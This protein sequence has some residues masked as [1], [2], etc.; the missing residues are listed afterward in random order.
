MGNP[1]KVKNRV[2][3]IYREDTVVSLPE[4]TV[5]HHHTRHWVNLETLVVVVLELVGHHGVRALVVVTGDHPA[6][7]PFT[8]LAALF[9][10]LDVEKFVCELWSVVVGV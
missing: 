2:L 6:D 7:F 1:I 5:R 4:I 3:D 9:G 8:R 10:Q